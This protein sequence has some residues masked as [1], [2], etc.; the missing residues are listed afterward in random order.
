MIGICNW[1]YD[2][3]LTAPLTLDLLSR[4]IH[5]RFRVFNAPDDVV[6]RRMAAAEPVPRI[7]LCGMA[8]LPLYER[9]T[10]FERPWPLNEAPPGET[11]PWP[12]EPKGEGLAYERNFGRSDKYSLKIER[13]TPGVSR[14]TMDREGEGSFT[15]RWC[16][17][18]SFRVSGYVRTQNVTS[19][20]ASLALRWTRYNQE[21]IY[22][23]IHSRRLTGTNDW[24]RLDVE[25]SG[26]HPP[27]CSAVEISLQL[28]GAGA[29]WFDDVEVT[30]L[31][32]PSGAHG[33]TAR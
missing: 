11:D 23:C 13:P 3:H 14:W 22:P 16:D 30:R 1:G 26:Q 28:D 17:V 5:R 29:A 8:E 18:M 7:E 6:R 24:T 15:E 20:G 4:P 10:S 25:L 21:P 27:D 33:I 12:W 32:A 19:P 2:I 31:P 9:K